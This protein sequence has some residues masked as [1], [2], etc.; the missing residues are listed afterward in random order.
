MNWIRLCKK[1]VQVILL[2][3]L[4]Q[5]TG[6]I[7]LPPEKLEVYCGG[8]SK[9]LVT[10]DPPKGSY[11]PTTFDR[12][13]HF[14]SPDYG[15]SHELFLHPIKSYRNRGIAAVVQRKFSIFSFRQINNLYCGL[16]NIGY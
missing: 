15:C 12:S 9:A 6:K 2:R 11:S 8:A 13:D 1:K 7:K 10:H 5:N 14:F 4:S 16:C 3:A